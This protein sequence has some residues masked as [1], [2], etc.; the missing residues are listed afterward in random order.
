MKKLIF[1]IFCV[2]LLISQSAKAQSIFISTSDELHK[3]FLGN[4]NTTLVGNFAPVTGMLDLA[5]HPNGNLYG[6][7]N[8][9]FYQIDTLTGAATYIGSHNAGITALA[10]DNN[11]LVYGVNGSGNF[12]TVDIT[13]GAATTLG[14]IGIG[15][16]GDLAFYDGQLYMAA[17]NGELFRIN[18]TNPNVSTSLGT[19]NIGVGVPFGLISTGTTCQVT[20]FLAGGN[21]ALFFVN[22]STAQTTLLC[23]NG[24]SITGLSSPNDYLASDCVLQVDL[25]FN[26]SSGTIDYDYAADTVCTA[27]V[28]IVDNDVFVY[29]PDL[30][31]SIVITISTGVLD[32][33]NEVLTLGTATNLMINGSGTSSITLVNNGTADYFN[34][35][36]ALLAMQYQNTS[37][38]PSFGQRQITFL[39]YSGSDVSPVSTTT[40]YL[41]SADNLQFDLGNDSTL[42]AGNTL[43]LNAT[44]PSA[45][46]YLWNDNSTNNQLQ[47]LQTNQY[48]ATAMNFCGAKSDTIMVTFEPLP[49]IDL[50]NDTTICNGETLNFDVTDT[51]T[52][53]Y[54]WQDGMT[55]PTYTI[56]QAGLYV[57]ELTSNCG[58]VSD[59]INVL[60][61][62]SNLSLD[63]GGDTLLCPDETRLLDATTPFVDSYQWNDGSTD[64]TLEITQG[65]TYI[66]TITDICN[67]SLS[68]TI[69]FTDFITELNIDLGNDTTLC[70]GELKLLNVTQPTAITYTWQ[71]SSANS[72]FAVT[73]EG[74]YSVVVTDLCGQVE[75]SI[76][77][78]YIQ[79][80]VIDLGEDTTVCEGRAV[81]LDAYD[82]NASTY[83]WQD[84]ST[85][86]AFNVEEEGV[87]KVIVANGCAIAEDSIEISY[88]DDILYIPFSKNQFICE[89]DSIWIGTSTENL[90]YEWSNGGSGRLTKVWELGTYTAN[91][92]N[93]CIDITKTVEV[94]T[95]DACCPVF[96]PNAFTPNG[97]TQNDVYQAYTSCVLNSFELIIFDRWGTVIFRSTDQNQGWDGTYNGKSLSPGIFIFK[98]SYNDGTFNHIETGD[99]TL[100]R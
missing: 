94:L 68:D 58:I 52:T 49:N 54:L 50:G 67:L 19:M 73:S 39:A 55:S 13:T 3:I 61:Y 47:T 89:G 93:G 64:S 88:A 72:S 40:F 4:C 87:Y 42:C 76:L 6:V 24:L 84:G 11:G 51:L 29:A 23:T 35:Q 34:Y 92:S 38:I 27:S 83:T 79:P 65:G 63:L 12:Y 82:E 70:E 43:T 1:T 48:I 56:S 9:D 44:A 36:D 86:S 59:S 26:N 33:T 98:V 37:T 75:D 81:I 71:D 78:N 16:A 32:G 17:A 95:S 21:G 18:P 28:S 25:D 20:Q 66:A 45:I 22:P 57:V 74:T 96:M 41:L 77:V 90:T 15:A 5:F 80:P 97:D 7:T 14:N 60:V 62:T 53:T 100:I 99:L 85:L 2:I 69:I 8:A 46:S 91:I 31:D 30:I 10:S